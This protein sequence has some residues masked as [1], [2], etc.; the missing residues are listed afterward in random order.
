MVINP[1]IKVGVIWAGVVGSYP[2]LFNR[3]TRTPSPNATPGFRGSW[4]RSLLSIFGS[5][6]D[7]PEFWDSIS[8]NAYLEDLSGPLQLHHGTADGSVPLVNSELL[9]DQTQ[10]AG[11]VVEF[12]TYD[13]DDHNLTKYFYLAMT[14]TVEFFDKYLKGS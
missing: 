8:A 10:R 13:G 1:K 14:R 2:D 7:N 9:Y 6:E 3:P 5:P 4:R 11:K 12:Y